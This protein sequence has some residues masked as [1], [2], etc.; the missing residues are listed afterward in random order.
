MVHPKNKPW[1]M[2]LREDPY[3]S[4]LMAG[5]MINRS[6]ELLSKQSERRLTSGDLY[7]AH[8]LGDG[9][10]SRML[11]LVEQRPQEKAPSA[12]PAAAR[13]NRSIFFSGA[14]KTRKDATVLEVQTRINSMIEKCVGRYAALVDRNLA[15][16]QVSSL[17]A[18]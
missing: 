8:F 14:S 16:T 18:H 13:A 15:S 2:S 9:G 6:R 4:A 1:I 10:A 3:L 11:K 5:E 7:L 17:D 12:F